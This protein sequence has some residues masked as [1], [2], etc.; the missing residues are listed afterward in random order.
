MK[1][2]INYELKKIFEKKKV[3]IF[4]LVTITLC[5]AIFLGRAYS[6]NTFNNL[7][8]IKESSAILV[9]EITPEKIEPIE[10]L[11]AEFINTPENFIE[12]EPG[13][14]MQMKQEV[15]AEFDLL[16][17]WL[18][19]NNFDKLQKDDI[20]ELEN[21]L[22]QSNLELDEK[23]SIEKYIEMLKEKGNLH[24][25]YNLFYDFS[26]YFS[27][28]S[29]PILGFLIIFFLS[30]VFSNEYTT[31][32][33]A[34]ILSS[35]NGKKKIILSKIIASIIAITCIFILVIGTYNLV[36][37]F[38]FGLEGGATS[39]TTLLYDPFIYMNSPY[40]LTMLQYF[41]LSILI[42]YLGCLGLGAFTLFIS[43][44]VS[45]QLFATM[46]NMALFFIPL[47]MVGFLGYDSIVKFSYM[48]IMQVRPLFYDF[49]ALVIFKNVVMTKDIILILLSI[50]TI[51]LGLLTFNSFRKHQVSN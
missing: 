22:K 31:N 4:S 27:T 3:I 8:R 7:D 29:A 18:S 49:S 43:S 48:S 15:N 30:P 37:A 39:F 14:E 26:E 40:N 28:M 11:Y 6:L 17:H 34:L 38:V 13:G 32:M 23:L 20:K 50:T 33:D 41:L 51:V 24:I 5:I 19:M 36:N 44:K 46:I 2:L 10:K 45:N 47:I 16:E 12:G 9:G 21:I 42:S 35:K 1:D 25:G